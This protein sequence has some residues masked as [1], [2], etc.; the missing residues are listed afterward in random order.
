MDKFRYF[1]IFLLSRFTPPVV[2]IFNAQNNISNKRAP[3]IGFCCPYER[4]C[5]A[6]CRLLERNE[7]TIPPTDCT[8][9][10]RSVKKLLLKLYFWQIILGKWSQPRRF[11]IVFIAYKVSKLRRK[12]RPEKMPNSDALH[13]TI[14]LCY[15][16]WIKRFT[17]DRL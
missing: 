5:Y 10:S 13:A 4:T 17:K 11:S 7:V 16:E 12:Y 15:L 1:F 8:S 9:W 2:R 3:A 6:K 14:F